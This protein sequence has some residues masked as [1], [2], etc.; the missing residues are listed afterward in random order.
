[1]TVYLGPLF[2][3]SPIERR[4]GI[5]RRGLRPRTD[6]AVCG[7]P[8]PREVTGHFVT[9]HEVEVV[10]AVCLG[11]SPALAWALSLPHLAFVV[12]L[13]LALARLLPDLERRFRYAAVAMVVVG[14]LPVVVLATDASSL[15]L[16]A[17]AFLAVVTQLYVVYLLFKAASAAPEHAERAAP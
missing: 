11:T 14:L 17:V 6:T 9:H 13:C 10:R 2:H 7:H 8:V 15:A 3:W 5:R 1:M 4:D 16:G 12:V